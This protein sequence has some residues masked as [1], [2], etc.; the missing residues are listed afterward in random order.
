[1]AGER[2]SWTL[3][4][5]HRYEDKVDKRLG[6]IEKQLDAIGTRLTLMIGA[7]GLLAFI[8]PVVAPFIRIWLGVD[9][10]APQN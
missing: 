10:P 3:A 5:Q 8:L 6:D 2:R 9:V 1:M 7:I 4:E